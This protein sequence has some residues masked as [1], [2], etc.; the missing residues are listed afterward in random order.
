[1]VLSSEEEFV[2]YMDM[3]KERMLL[4]LRKFLKG[5]DAG[6]QRLREDFQRMKRFTT[7]ARGYIQDERTARKANK[8]TKSVE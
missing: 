5:G 2:K 6:S 3:E 4:N 8:V 7:G 1:M